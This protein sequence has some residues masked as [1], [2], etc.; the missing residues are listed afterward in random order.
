DRRG[1]TGGM[2]FSLDEI[3]KIPD[4]F[5]IKRVARVLEDTKPIF[6]APVLFGLV[7]LCLF[8]EWVLRKKCRLI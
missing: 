6:N 5:K 7:L 3:D 4:A 1:S 2:V 8:V